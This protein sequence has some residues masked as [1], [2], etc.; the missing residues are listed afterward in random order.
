MYVACNYNV[1]KRAY[2]GDFESISCENQY[3]SQNIFP[4]P[5]LRISSG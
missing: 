5:Y 3:G 2:G 1:I 4:K